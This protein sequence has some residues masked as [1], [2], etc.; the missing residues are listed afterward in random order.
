[1]LKMEFDKT[2]EVVYEEIPF[3]QIRSVHS[4]LEELPIR[5]ENKTFDVDKRKKNIKL[6]IEGKILESGNICLSMW[7]DKTTT[8]RTPRISV[9][10]Y[11]LEKLSGE[12]YEIKSE[13]L[14][15]PCVSITRKKDITFDIYTINKNIQNSQ[16][17]R[18]E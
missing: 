14:V 6:R 4:F 8:S 13:L 2:L 17:E 18:E 12:D 1:M 10:Y 7:P 5:V 3:N 15:K 11:G 9:A 16:S